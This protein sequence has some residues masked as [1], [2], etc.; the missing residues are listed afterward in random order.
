M[1]GEKTAQYRLLEDSEAFQSLSVDDEHSLA[2][3]AVISDGQ[4]PRKFH[5]KLSFGVVVLIFSIAMNIATYIQLRR[6]LILTV[7]A[8]R[9]KFGKKSSGIE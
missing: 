9:S 6:Q 2:N 5:R 1:M 4:R 8:R 3:D 7:N